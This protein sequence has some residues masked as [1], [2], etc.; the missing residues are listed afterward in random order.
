M[1]KL[2]NFVL[3]NTRELPPTESPKRKVADPAIGSMS[4]LGSRAS[5]FS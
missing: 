4:D 5:G 3:S 2:P 1:R